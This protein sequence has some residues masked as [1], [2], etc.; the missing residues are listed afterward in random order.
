LPR[1]DE[2]H[3]EI[4]SSLQTKLAS[5]AALKYGLKVFVSNFCTSREVIVLRVQLYAHCNLVVFDAVAAWTCKAI[6][7]VQLLPPLLSVRIRDSV[8]PHVRAC[9]FEVTCCEAM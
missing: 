4:L 8:L 2:E 6:V 3:A 9:A 7:R 1:L 5:T